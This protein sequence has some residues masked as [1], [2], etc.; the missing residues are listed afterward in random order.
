MGLMELLHKLSEGKHEYGFYET[1]DGGMNSPSTGY[2]PCPSCGMEI[3]LKCDSS[4]KS[5]IHS[6]REIK[7][8]GF[9]TLAKECSN[10]ACEWSKVKPGDIQCQ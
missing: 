9:F 1:C 7:I 6:N 5:N 8:D 2:L 4:I 3:E 10:P